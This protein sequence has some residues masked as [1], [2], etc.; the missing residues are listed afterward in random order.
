MAEGVRG[1]RREEVDA[2]ERTGLQTGIA[3]GWAPP[4]SAV[5][6]SS[7][8]LRG[9]GSFRAAIHARPSSVATRQG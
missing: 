9:H 6:I 8:A 5:R 2:L 1:D 3:E 7:R 4:S